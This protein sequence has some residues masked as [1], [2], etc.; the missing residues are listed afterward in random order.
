MIG[1]D[2]TFNCMGVVDN[3]EVAT[4]ETLAHSGDASTIFAAAPDSSPP[5]H[6]FFPFL[7]LCWYV[8][9]CQFVSLGI[10]GVS[11]SIWRNL[12]RIGIYVCW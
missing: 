6:T 3:I 11:E 10:E 2:F 8:K 7:R 1:L 12:S 4:T 5:P 9:V